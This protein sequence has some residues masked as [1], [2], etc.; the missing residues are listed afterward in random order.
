MIITDWKVLVLLKAANS[1]V[2][3]P[4]KQKVTSFSTCNLQCV[5]KQLA[6]LLKQASCYLHQDLR[7]PIQ[8]HWVWPLATVTPVHYI[9][10][11]MLPVYNRCNA[12]PLSFQTV[13]RDN[14]FNANFIHRW[15]IR[16]RFLS[17]YLSLSPPPLSLSPSPP[18]PLSLSLSLPLS[19]SLSVPQLHA[20][21]RFI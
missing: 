4:I 2:A 10:E 11:D 14:P 17:L 9:K 12:I 21:F 8:L 1:H 15:H 13:T 18:P 19:L 6:I 5:D 16:S 3:K 7:T 20:I